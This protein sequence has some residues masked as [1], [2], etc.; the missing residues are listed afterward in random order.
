MKMLVLVCDYCEARIKD[1]ELHRISIVYPDM[2]LLKM[3]VCPGCIKA[4]MNLT[5]K[6]TK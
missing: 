4:G 1:G 2:K 3:D 6:G 5:Q